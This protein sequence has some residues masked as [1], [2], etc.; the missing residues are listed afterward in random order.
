MTDPQSMPSAAVGGFASLARHTFT[1]FPAASSIT[2]AFSHVVRAYPTRC[3][4]IDGRRRWNYAELDTITNRVAAHLQAMGV[5]RGQCVGT[6]LDRSAEAI[7]AMLAILKLGA[8]YVP[9]DPAAPD[10]RLASQS[11][12][13]AIKVLTIAPGQPSPS[14]FEGSAFEVDLAMDAAA[15]A[16]PPLDIHPLE[17]ATVIHTSGSTN[18][19][20]GVGV[21]HGAI[22]EL[23]AGAAYCGFLPDDVVYH[24]MSIAFDG[25]TFEI[26]GALLSGACLVVAPP[27]TSLQG[28]VELVEARAVSVLLLPTGVFNALS[29]DMLRRLARV[30]VLLAGGDVMSPHSAALFLGNGGRL[31][32]NGYGPTEITTFSHCHAMAAA[33]PADTAI[34]VGVPVHGTAAY[35]LD[36]HGTPVPVGAEGELFIAGTGLAQGYLG[37]PALT[38]ERFVPDPFATDGSRMYR[39]GDL[40]CQAPDGSLSF[41]GRADTQVKIRGFRVELGEIE[42]CLRSTGALDDA[43]VVH[44]KNAASTSQLYAY[45]VRGNA[46]HAPSEQ[47]LLAQLGNRLPDYMLPRRILFV[48]VLP[49]TINGKVDRRVLAARAAALLEETETAA[50]P[51]AESGDPLEQSLL[52]ELTHL[53]GQSS[54]A[55]SDNFFDA[56]GDSLTALRFCALVGEQHAVALSLATLFDM[57]SLGELVEHIRALKTARATDA[58]DLGECSERPVG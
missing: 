4:L 36:A 40:V 39:T 57:S 51:I 25:S 1:P 44:V 3:A 12:H 2:Q 29:R 7:V 32:V 47:A 9:F 17:L 38:A 23:I 48:D 15:H 46:T 53:L 55:R 52:R 37:N 34:P 42:T 5:E 19:P 13:A 56:G 31:L 11:H 33:P 24:G 10:E 43:C 27:G 22:V 18:S 6:Y 8:A 58:A 50:A 20:K 14:W 30:R 54:L 26:W 49:L 16:M 45:C 28:L 21:T 41:I 35:V